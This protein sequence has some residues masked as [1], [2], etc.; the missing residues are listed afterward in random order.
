MKKLLIFLLAIP[1]ICQATDIDDISFET[2]RW[3]LSSS[4]VSWNGITSILNIEGS[5]TQYERATITVDIPAATTDLF[6]S[7]QV[8][9]EDITVGSQAWNRPKLKIYQANGTTTIKAC[10]INDPI[11]GSWY[12]FT[13]AIE[14]F[15][16]AHSQVVLEIGMQNTIGTFQVRSPR[17][18]NDPPDVFPYDVPVDPV[19]NLDLSSGETEAFNNDL[20]SSNCHFSFNWPDASWSSPE[21]ANTINNV[22][23]HSNY[24][25]PGGTVGNFYDWTSDGYH[26]DASTFAAPF[27]QNL[28]NNNFV[29]DYTGFKNQVI[30]SNGSA[31]LMFNVIHDNI[32]TATS[33]LQSRINDGLNIEWI[34]LGNENY[35]PTQAY[36]NISDGWET[37]DVDAYIS[38][39]GSLSASLK[40][41]DPNI[42]VAVNINHLTYEVGG[43]SDRLANE[44]YYDATVLHNYVSPRNATLDF[45]TGSMLLQSYKQTKKNLDE[46]KV[47]FGTTPTIVTEWGLQGAPESFLSVIASAEIFMALLDEGFNDGVVTQAG[48]H[49]F[50]HSDNNQHQTM[51][52]KEGSNVRFTATGVFYSKLFEVFKDATIF[53]ASSSSPLLDTDLPSVNARAVDIG[54]SI[55]VF[56][57][58]KLPVASELQVM[59]DGL[60]LVND[61]QMETYTEDVN[62][63]W[64]NGYTDVSSPW[65]KTIGSG[66]ISLPPY[67][68]SV[69]TF[70]KTNV[71]TSSSDELIKE[72]ISVF[73]NPT[74]GVVQFSKT[75][76]YQI[77]DESGTMLSQGT[78]KVVDISEYPNGVYFFRLQSNE[79]TEVI[80]IVKE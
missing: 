64:P 42:K 38:H 71:I 55:K 7:G 39:T 60:N 68:L 62:N 20:L 4:N 26:N 25:F 15:N 51:M 24:R 5:A 22:F 50:Y 14:G 11:E 78:N 80:K 66:P 30:S 53:K 65:V 33:R 19:C 16:S 61:Y 79:K 17:I 72:E 67:S 36:G 13:C 43:W 52:Y 75:S 48:I 40:T 21:V 58:N 57:I 76:R 41:I 2:D 47:H 73:P 77:T 69:T 35:F 27:R 6:F 74:K 9:L 70:A 10:N 37:P 28:F 29:F 23:P 54:D 3:E 59:Y 1:L 18:T 45:T 34:E 32:A 49:M 44:T 63:G 8:Y 12:G 56:A 46:Y 31:T